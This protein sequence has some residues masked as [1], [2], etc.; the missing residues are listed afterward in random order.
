MH[1]YYLLQVGVLRSFCLSYFLAFPW[2]TLA[3]RRRRGKWRRSRRRRPWRPEP[4]RRSSDGGAEVGDG[5]L[6]RCGG[7]SLV[8]VGNDLCGR[9]HPERA[10]PAAATSLAE[11]L[12]DEQGIHQRLQ[13]R[14]LHRWVRDW[15]DPAN[16][17][18]L[19]LLMLQ[20]RLLI[21]TSSSEI[22]SA[23]FLLHRSQAR[24]V[25]T[26]LYESH[27]YRHN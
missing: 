10:S 3:E 16:L 4:R 11:P 5:S 17:G 8:D 9:R 12:A 14:W 21:W 2:W 25:N 27:H 15:F 23:S 13:P 26:S 6:W 22:L 7:D 1:W 20:L 24:I 18:A 19:A